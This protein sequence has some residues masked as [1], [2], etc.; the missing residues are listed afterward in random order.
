MS[1]AL[2]LFLAGLAAGFLGGLVG[3]GGGIIFAPV[4][5][6][7]YRSAG[8]PPEVL[9]PLTIGTSLLC[10][11]VVAVA[12]A[13]FQHRRRAVEPRVALFAG[14][15][16]AAAVFAMTRFVTTQPWYDAT[17]FQIVFSL[18]LLATVVQMI[19]P[20]RH[21]RVPPEAEGT[22]SRD[23]VPWPALFGVGAAA[24]AVASAVGVGGGVV[25][26]PAYHHLLRLPIHRA[27][28][29]SSATIPLI[30]LLGVVGYA[31]AGSDATVPG[32][33]LGYVDA[34]RA[35]LLALPALFSARLGV[36]TA[37]RIDTRALRLSFAVVA[38]FVALRLLY[39]ALG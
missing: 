13:W 6:F 3:V 34:G 23:R 39:G 30:A 5:L 17:V 11:F 14:L 26:V 31:I 2:L 38:V 25:L 19:R 32:T 22:P 21:G 36:W 18:L 8:V 10:T 16:S 37:H 7:Y 1:T 4:L 35:L 12:S 28:G 27:V 29:T 24:G 15:S 20:P 33:A 9:A